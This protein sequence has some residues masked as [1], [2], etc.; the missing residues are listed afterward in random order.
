MIKVNLKNNKTIEIDKGSSALDIAKKISSSLAKECV[1]AKINGKLV[2]AKDVITQDEINLEIISAKEKN[3]IE[4]V[5]HSCAHLLGHALK[6]LYPKVKMAIGPVIENGF[7]YDIDLDEKL[8]TKDLQKISASMSKLAK[9]NYQV[10]KKITPITKAKEIF[11]TRGETYKL[12]IIEDIK[13]ET[14]NLYHHLE[15]IDMCRGPHVPSMKFCQNFSL[16]NISGSY[17]R[18]DSKNQVL[19]RIYGAAFATKD[20]LKEHLHRLEEAKKRDH[21]IL[22]KKLNLFHTQEESPG[23]A[24]WHENGAILF[25]VV[26]SFMQKQLKKYNYH[27]VLSPLV[28]DESLW[29]K[30]GHMD[31]YKD[32]IF[33]TE[34][35]KRNY[36]IKPMNC[37]GH[38]Q[39]FNQG[40]KSYRD[41]PYKMAE[42]GLVHRNEPSGSLHGLMRVRSFTQDDAHIF[43]TED[44]QQIEQEISSCIDMVFDTYKSFGFEN[45]AVKLSTRPDQRVGSDEIWDKTENI[46]KDVLES[47]KIEFQLQKGEGAFY[48]PK[49]EFVLKD[50]LNR[51]WQCGTI[52][53][54]FS[55]PKRLG[56][57]YVDADSNKKTPVMIH[58]AIVGSLE[59]FIAILLEHYAGKMPFWLSPVQIMVINVS[60]KQSEY[61]KNLTK[62]LENLGYRVKNDLRN[63]K[64]GFKIRTHSIMSVYYTIIVGEKEVSSNTLSTRDIKANE[65]NNISFDEF[66]LTL[67]NHEFS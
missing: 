64:I 20:E 67:K 53:L 65:K 54:D 29:Q 40:L 33:A 35:E 26:K 7:Y 1:A 56:A 34:S 60:E 6:R 9:S 28:M 18:G 51:A 36:A 42:F 4:I 52:Q 58:R 31:K 11:K 17:W 66:V 39:I 2:D 62:K 27:E 19:Q 50:C 12:E 59:R 47:K 41:L 10:E 38:L 55:M 43:T 16:T 48:G 57:T 5:R 22:G 3:G 61:A 14:C 49:I 46:L 30:S 24:F 45:V 44:N 23:M 32:M 37:P 63:E 21:R 13:D 25:N 8:T 15:Y